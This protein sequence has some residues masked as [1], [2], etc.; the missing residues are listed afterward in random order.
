MAKKSREKGIRIEREVVQWLQDEGL[1]ASKE[2]RS[3]YAGE[4]LKVGDEWRYEVKARVT[5]TAGG[6]RKVNGYIGEA[7]GLFL[8]VDGSKVPELVVLSV[9]H[10]LELMT[11]QRGASDTP[12]SK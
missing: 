9:E 3:G 11:G 6:W 10:W 12:V 8:R 2:S 1:P 4:D 7:D 5:D